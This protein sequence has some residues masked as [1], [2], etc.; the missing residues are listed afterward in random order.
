MA[1]CDQDKIYLVNYAKMCEHSELYEDMAE[2][3]VYRCKLADELD[4][5]ER[6][7]LSNAFKYLVNSLRFSYRNICAIEETSHYDST[8]STIIKGLKEKL[9]KKID[10]CC[11]KL[12]KLLACDLQPN[13]TS[14]E[15]KAFL[16]KLEA[17][18]Y[19]YRC[20]VATGE[21]RDALIEETSDLYVEGTELAK[22]LPYSN[23]IRLGLALNFAVLYDEIMEDPS[24]ACLIAKSAFDRAFEELQDKNYESPIILIEDSIRILQ[25]LKDNLAHWTC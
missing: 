19:R 6:N 15:I 25:I 16:K 3:M 21:G 23:P 1:L 24:K 11:N 10:S 5:L 9:Y 13:T 4:D 2:A 8:R 18:Y 22:E 12:I 7:L 17:D 20:E 14:K